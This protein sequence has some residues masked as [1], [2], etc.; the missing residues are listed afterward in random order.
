MTRAEWLASLQ[1]FDRAWLP[2]KKPGTGHVLTVCVM[3]DGAVLDADRGVCGDLRSAG[4]EPLPAA[5]WGTCAD[6]GTPFR[7]DP[8]GVDECERC[9]ERRI[10]A[11]VCQS[12]CRTKKEHDAKLLEQR[13]RLGT[14]VPEGVELH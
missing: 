2:G 3:G 9:F 8:F 6:C 13:R 7:S 1:T 11:I 4:I 5:P 10:P 14:A 12:G